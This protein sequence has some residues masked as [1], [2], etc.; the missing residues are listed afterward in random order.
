MSICEFHFTCT[1]LFMSEF[2]TSV[3]VAFRCRCTIQHLIGWFLFLTDFVIINYMQMEFFFSRH[4]LMEIFFFIFFLLASSIQTYLLRQISIAESAISLSAITFLPL[5]EP[6]MV[7]TIEH[8]ASIIRSDND[9]A[10]NPANFTFH[11]LMKINKL[12]STIIQNKKQNKIKKIRIYLQP[13]YGW[14]Q[15]WLLPTLQWPN[16]L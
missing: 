5:N 2:D 10:E 14:H 8:L 4:N 11:N 15:F 12:F 16:R 1:L 9:W 13:L 7:T 6:S 3:P